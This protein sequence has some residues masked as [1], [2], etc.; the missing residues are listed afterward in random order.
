MF[1]QGK[2]YRQ[3]TTQVYRQQSCDNGGNHAK[4]SSSVLNIVPEK[5]QDSSNCNE[6]VSSH[7][8]RALCAGCI[9]FVFPQISVF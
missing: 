4:V 1:V 8:G 9:F 5:Q 6:L 7:G 3:E 2:E